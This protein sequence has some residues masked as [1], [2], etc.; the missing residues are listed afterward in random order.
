MA[1]RYLSSRG[2]A[3]SCTWPDRPTGTTR[4]AGWGLQSQLRSSGLS[5]LPPS[6]A[7]GAPTRAT[8]PGAHWPRTGRERAARAGIHRRLRRQR[9][10][11]ARLM[12]A[13][14]EAGLDVPADVSVV[15]LGDIPEAAHFWPPL[16]TV[17]QDVR[18]LGRSQVGLLIDAIGRAWGANGRISDGRRRPRCR[19]TP[20]GHQEV[21]RAGNAPIVL[22]IVGRAAR[23]QQD[24]G[25]LCTSGC[26]ERSIIVGQTPRESDNSK[27]RPDTPRLSSRPRPGRATADRL[28]RER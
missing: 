6:S 21:G 20:P 10:A 18:E 3:A 7:T 17:R 26:T 4:R 27:K 14:R 28:P 2:T 13:F 25:S 12:H 11:G 1:V 15:G 24:D 8:R 16:T 9:P 23:P 19:R 5:I 22:P